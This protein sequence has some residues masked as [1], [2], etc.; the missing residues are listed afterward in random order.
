MSLTKLMTKRRNYTI[1][2]LSQLLI[3]FSLFPLSFARAQTE[4]IPF[5]GHRLSGEFQDLDSGA[6]ITVDDAAVRG[7]VINVDDRPGA[8]YEF[9]YSKQSSRLSAGVNLPGNVLFDIDMTYIHMGGI[10]LRQ[11]DPHSQGFFGA[12]IGITHFSPGLSGVS[13]ETYPSLSVTSGLKFSFGK[14]LGLRL[15]VRAYGTSVNNNTAIFCANGACRLRFSGNM[16]T[17]FESTAGI[18]L[19][20]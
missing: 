13:S 11:L 9:L 17:Q 16:F 3:L 7:F 19:R 14:H 10:L 1:T 18:I 8:A 6:K 4:L 15:D 2:C 12:A 5:A 20:F